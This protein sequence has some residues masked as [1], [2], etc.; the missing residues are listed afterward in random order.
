MENKLKI[1]YAT[2][3]IL[4]IVA[5]VAVSAS[6]YGYGEGSGEGTCN[7]GVVTGEN[8]GNVANYQTIE[9]DLIDNMSIIYEFTSPEFS[10]YQV[11]ITSKEYKCQVAVRLEHLKGTS[12]LA[13]VD[14]PGNVYVNEN[15]WIGTR[16]IQDD[17]LI[18][19]RVKNSWMSDNSIT[20][21]DIR[22]L[23]YDIKEGNWKQL[24]T[25]TIG[26][27]DTYMYFDTKAAGILILAIS[28]L[29]EEVVTRVPIVMP[30]PTVKETTIIPEPIGTTKAPGFE[31]AIAAM[32]ISAIYIFR[33]R[34]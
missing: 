33:R 30:P 10:I 2:F 4:M 13:K 16:I 27:D 15:I 18:R 28:G 8:L 1:V 26:T 14:A 12:K 11:I 29:K 24:E 20:S 21:N 34:S 3:A 22:L 5:I 17:I 9:K 32:A 31:I 19:F 23:Q 25:N 6:S 7:E